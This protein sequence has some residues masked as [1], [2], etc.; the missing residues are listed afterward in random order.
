MQIPRKY[1][2]VVLPIMVLLIG[3]APTRGALE[4]HEYSR[5][6]MG[7][8]VRLVVYTADETTAETAC[9]AA[10]ERVAELEDCMSDYQTQ[11]ELMGLCAKA[12]Q[13][14]VPVSDA[15][16]RVLDYAQQVSQE[17]DGAFDV[18]VGPLV[19]LWRTARKTGALPTVQAI[20]EAKANVG[21]RMMKIDR[22][23]RTVELMKSGMKLDLGGIAKGYAG[24]EAI[25]VLRKHG[26]RSALF[27]AGGDIVVSDA[28]PGRRG[29]MIDSPF[30]DQELVLSNTAIST[31]GDTAQY[32]EIGGRRYSHVVDP[33]SG[34]GLSEH[35][36]AT[37]VAPRGITTDALSTAATLVGRQRGEALCRRFGVKRFWIGRSDATSPGQSNR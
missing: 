29:W 31:S 7:V 36:M 35:F 32:V 14:P 30:H 12:G 20:K 11:S 3:C 13:G 9:R 24:D 21:W 25:E 22:H 5:I 17:S 27:E 23:A 19:A 8:Q 18:T 37:I 10:F 34:L 28:P 26:V 6:L 15:L 4:R 2:F 16:L 1:G 33:K